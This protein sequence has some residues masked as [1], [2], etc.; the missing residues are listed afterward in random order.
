V[1]R[2]KNYTGPLRPT[3]PFHAAAP[4]GWT[5]T[6]QGGREG[7]WVIYKRDCPEYLDNVPVFRTRA[8]AQRAVEQTGRRKA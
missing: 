3:K 1:G 5:A 8:D 6:E 2:W 7:A 4:F